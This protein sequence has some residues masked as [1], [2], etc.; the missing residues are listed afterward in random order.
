MVCRVSTKI[1]RSQCTP[2]G[3]SVTHGCMLM[4]THYGCQFLFEYWSHISRF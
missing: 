4:K 2:V 3:W 1:K